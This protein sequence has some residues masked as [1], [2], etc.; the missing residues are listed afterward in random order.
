MH[1][2]SNLPSMRTKKWVH[3]L[4][5]CICIYSVIVPKSDIS[6]VIQQV[7]DMMY[8]MNDDLDEQA[9][10][11]KANPAVSCRAI[12]DSYPDMLEG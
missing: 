12:K 8:D 4:Q 5:L 7:V 2:S 10:G 6:F 9:D 11:S 1:A 3:W